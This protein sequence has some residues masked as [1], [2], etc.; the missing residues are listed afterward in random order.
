MKKSKSGMQSKGLRSAKRWLVGS[1]A[2]ALLTALSCRLRLN[3]TTA[4]LL[5]LIVVVLMSV[6]EDL[7]SSIF[8]SG[9]AVVCLTYIAPPSD[10]FRVQDPS[11]V[12]AIVAF[13]IVSLVTI[14]LMHRVQK[15]ANEAVGSVRRQLVEIEERQRRRI[16]RDLYDDI[17]Q[18]LTLVVVRL[19]GL[20]RSSST[21]FRE[22]AELSEQTSK[23]ATDVQVLAHELYFAKL[24]YL[25]LAASM[26]NFCREF[27]RQREVEIEFR[28]NNVPSPLPPRVSACLFRILQ[29]ALHNCAKHSGV[30]HFGVELRATPY[31]LH[32][33][34]HDSGFGFDPEEKLKSG[35]L[36]LLSMQERMKLANGKLYIDSQVKRGTT[37]H[38]SVPLNSLNGL[39]PARP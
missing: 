34:V 10:S 13:F 6:T 4:T 23:L 31:A 8:V 5:Y 37:V 15:L 20:N 33:T 9:I 28:N 12:V 36:G 22:I 21:A 32:L 11:D 29:E 27:S 17:C 39:R 14:G 19:Q 24:E 38:A 1:L 35:G 2:I 18:R 25:G 7:A 30:R 26:R 16:A 3:F